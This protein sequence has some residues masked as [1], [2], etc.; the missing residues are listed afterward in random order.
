MAKRIPKK[1]NQLFADRAKAENEREFSLDGDDEGAETEKL[2]LAVL[3]GQ[4]TSSRA[5]R[6][7]DSDE[8]RGFAG[9]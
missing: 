7:M 1:E 5:G 2:D 3:H 6:G 8:Y 4:G 9:F